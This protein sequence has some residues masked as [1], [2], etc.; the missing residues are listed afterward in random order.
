MV[1]HA[2]VIIDIFSRYVVGW[3]IAG[4][5]SGELAKQLVSE[6]CTKQ[7]ISGEGLYF[8]VV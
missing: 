7:E 2:Y 3:M 6:T 8:C 4:R 5:E 1:N